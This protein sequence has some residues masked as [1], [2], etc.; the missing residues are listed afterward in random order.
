M[1]FKDITHQRL[2]RQYI[3][4]PLWERP[5]EVVEWMGAIQAQDYLGSLWSVGLRMKSATEALIENA[6]EQKKII[7]TWPMRGTL[8]MV[9]PGDVRNML[10]YLAPRQIKRMEPI[11]K[12]S[13]L[14]NATL[15]KA[16]KIVLKGLATYKQLT[17][18]AL[19]ELLKR[20]NIDTGDSRGL[21]VIVHLAMSG[22]ICLGPRD[23][24]Q[25]T[26]VLLDDWLP[27]TN[28]LPKEEALS[29]L[30][31]QYFSGHGP[32]T[33]ADFGW[34]TG[35]TL[36]EATAVVALVKDKFRE[37]TI[38]EIAYYSADSEVK[39]SKTNKT[40]NCYLLPGFDEYVLSYAD[41]SPVVDVEQ[42]KQIAR[43]K[44]GQLS[45][46]IIIKGQV[47]GTWKRVLKNDSVLIETKPFVKFSSA[48]NKAIQIAA[49]RYVDFLGLKVKLL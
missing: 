10:H 33:I 13:G 35:L 43:T 7:R 44:N 42:F 14:D 31:I 45:S 38:N 47:A 18:P 24:K 17:R 2:H 3:S 22:D 37:D 46:T 12:Q 49:Q 32:A 16:R 20:A 6:I 15:N 5:E 9:P 36:R 48:D 11:L 34:W 29:S 27:E 30:A 8:H 19:Y 40:S 1:T 26:Y 41:R 4:H 21:H 28:V 23:G 39:G 25:T